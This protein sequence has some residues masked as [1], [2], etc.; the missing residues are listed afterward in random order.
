M[1]HPLVFLNPAWTNA[2]LLRDW[3]RI[4]QIARLPAL[5][6]RVDEH[7]ARRLI[8]H[9]YGSGAYGTVMPTGTPGLVFKVTSDPTEARFAAVARTLKPYPHGLVQYGPVIQLQGAHDGRPIYALWREEAFDV[10]NVLPP[11]SWTGMRLEQIRGYAE[12]AFRLTYTPQSR[13]SHLAPILRSSKRY[14]GHTGFEHNGYGPSPLRRFG[15]WLEGRDARAGFGVDAVIALA[16]EIAHDREAPL[17][18]A[19]IRDLGR[20]GLLVGD[21]H[22]GNIGRVRRD[23]RMQVVITDP[24]NVAFLTNRYDAVKVPTLADVASTRP[25][26]ARRKRVA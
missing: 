19:A 9:E 7:T 18:G 22:E 3:D 2:A 11:N 5:M 6:P 8:A 12:P 10:G 16:N 15:V 26:K 21:V 13:K 4:Q 14:A 20:K 24:G 23:G 1:P 25:M 17:V